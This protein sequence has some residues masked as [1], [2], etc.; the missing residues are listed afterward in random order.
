[1][2]SHQVLRE[3]SLKILQNDRFHQEMD[4]YNLVTNDLI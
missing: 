4:E 2:G 1:M 3:N